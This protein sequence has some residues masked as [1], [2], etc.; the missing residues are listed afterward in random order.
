MYSV[1]LSRTRRF[2]VLR[3]HEELFL[4][5]KCVFFPTCVNIAAMVGRS[6]K[7]S[8]IRLWTLLSKRILKKNWRILVATCGYSRGGAKKFDRKDLGY[9]KEKYKDS[10]DGDTLPETNIVSEIGHPKRKW[11]LPT[12]DFQG[13]YMLVSGR[14]FDIFFMLKPCPK[15]VTKSRPV[16][17]CTV[18]III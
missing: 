7:R 1:G 13:L 6:A 11:H 15:D 18:V 9:L 4:R 5:K 2:R 16:C 17:F 12:I 8:G 10:Q 3:H 14:V